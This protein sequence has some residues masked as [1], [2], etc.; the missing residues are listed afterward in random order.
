MTAFLKFIVTPINR[1]KKIRKGETKDFW[2]NHT[3]RTMSGKNVM[4]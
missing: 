1:K 2:R 3:F 4:F